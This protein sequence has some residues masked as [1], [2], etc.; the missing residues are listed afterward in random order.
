MNDLLKKKQKQKNEM[1]QIRHHRIVIINWQ[2][3][4]LTFASLKCSK[5][6]ELYCLFELSK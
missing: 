4:R 3:G 6:V 2:N 1:A 5:A